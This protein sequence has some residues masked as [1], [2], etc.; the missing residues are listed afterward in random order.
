MMVGLLTV[1]QSSGVGPPA[2]ELFEG[3]ALGLLYRTE[4]KGGV[5]FVSEGLKSNDSVIHR[6]DGNGR[7]PFQVP[8]GFVRLRRWWLVAQED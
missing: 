5:K 1:R 6:G 2:Q 3:L 4:T 8:V 7:S